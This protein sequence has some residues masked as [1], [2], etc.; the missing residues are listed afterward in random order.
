MRLF[1]RRLTGAEGASAVEYAVILGG[2][3]FGLIAVVLGLKGAMANAIGNASDS[4]AVLS[5]GSTATPSNGP[6]SVVPPPAAPSVSSVPKNG[7]ADISWGAVNGATSYVVS[8]PG[9]AVTVNA[10]ATTATCA[11]LTNGTQY[12]IGVVAK[13]NSGSSTAGTTTVIPRTVPG[14]PTALLSSTDSGV[15]TV[16]WSPPASNGGSPITGYTVTP[17]GGGGSCT[18]S[19][20]GATCTGLTA[21]RQY[22]FTVLATNAAGDSPTVTTSPAV[23]AY[24]KGTGEFEVDFGGTPGPVA[25]AYTRGGRSNHTIGSTSPSTCGTASVDRSSGAVT[26]AP[27]ASPSASCLAGTAVTVQ[28]NY[29]SGGRSRNES[30]VFYVH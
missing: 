22:T 13:G 16:Q 24:T 11:G 10:P 18:V 27:T 4:Q 9:G 1:R 15:V 3:V 28:V 12:T 30:F 20:L 25:P 21:G 5:D 2:T 8:C 17:V 26:F 14:A 6:T 19:G 23:I 29:T 7:A